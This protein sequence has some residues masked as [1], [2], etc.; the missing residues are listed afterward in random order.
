M[1]PLFDKLQVTVIVRDEDGTLPE[2]EE[3]TKAIYEQRI[4]DIK[5]KVAKVIAQ[6]ERHLSKEDVK[7]GVIRQIGSGLAWQ[8]F[9]NERERGTLRCTGR[10]T[11]W[12]PHTKA[13]KA[14]SEAEITDMCVDMAVQDQ[15]HKRQLRQQHGNMAVDHVRV[16]IAE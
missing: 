11:R 16:G 10:C 13:S 8:F 7:E 6:V 15:G 1:E 12:I 5:A 4:C 2:F 9:S 3:E 14:S